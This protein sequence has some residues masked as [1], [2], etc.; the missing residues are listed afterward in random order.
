MTIGIRY[1]LQSAIGCN[2]TVKDRNTK[3]SRPQGSRVAGVREVRGVVRKDNG[4]SQRF[5]TVDIEAQNNLVYAAPGNLY[6]QLTTEAFDTTPAPTNSAAGLTGYRRYVT[7]RPVIVPTSVP[8]SAQNISTFDLYINN[9]FVNPEIHDIY[10]KRI[11][12]SLI[13]VYRFQTQNQTVP[14]F[15]VLLAQ[16]K[17]PIETMFAGLRP[18]FNVTNPVY[19]SSGLVSS[20]NENVHRDWHR[21]TL[22]TDHSV[23]EVC[24]ATLPLPVAL[25]GALTPD[26]T[27]SVGSFAGAAPTSMSSASSVDALVY[28]VP[29]KTLATV[30]ITAHGINIYDQ[31]QAEFF[32]D[33]IPYQ[34]GGYN[35]VT[36]ED[37]GAVM[38]NFN[39]YP[40]T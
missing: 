34:Y 13:R 16:L 6:L 22:L 30:K 23:A 21:M 31:Y 10:I 37:V 2:N 32:A 36:P 12:F 18:T 20:G 11:G 35:I 5:I 1:T 25:A 19:A 9:I 3:A 15:D 39:L 26:T 4:S 17:W 24:T 29:T 33:Y 40:G 28:P 27:S 7:R 14:N 38:I 8:S